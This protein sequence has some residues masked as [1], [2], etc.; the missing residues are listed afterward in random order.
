MALDLEPSSV[1]R[2]GRALDFDAR[3]LLGNDRELLGNAR[4]DSAT[5]RGKTA[6]LQ[7][8]GFKFE[9]YVEP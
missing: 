1:E 6:V 8:C 2:P 4:H 5:Q 7:G 3:E 9:G